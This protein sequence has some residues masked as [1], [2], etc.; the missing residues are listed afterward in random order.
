MLRVPF[1]FPSLSPFLFLFLFCFR[2]E[3]PD[4]DDGSLWL[5]QLVAFLGGHRVTLPVLPRN[6]AT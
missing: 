5:L 3:K 2:L 4:G 6:Y 1:P